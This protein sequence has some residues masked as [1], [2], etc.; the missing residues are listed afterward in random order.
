MASVLLG[1]GF[2]VLR[3]NLLERRL[4]TRC[5]RKACDPDCL[6]ASSAWRS[7]LR[8]ASTGYVSA[9]Q[10]S[11]GEG[12]SGDVGDAYRCDLQHNPLASAWVFDVAG[13]RYVQTVASCG[14]GL[15]NR[16]DLCVAE[17]AV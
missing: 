4:G 12:Q 10:G 14:S 1:F 11:R 3:A 17:V 16:A 15:P 7:F 13:Y 9:F 2:E 6:E 5:P 8:A